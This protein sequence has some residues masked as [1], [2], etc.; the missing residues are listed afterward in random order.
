MDPQRHLVCKSAMNGEPRML[1]RVQEDARIMPYPEAP[2]I[3]ASSD[4]A[5]PEI[6]PPE[7]DDDALV[8]GRDLMA[9]LDEVAAVTGQADRELDQKIK[10]LED[11]IAPMKRVGSLERS[12]QDLRTEVEALRTTKNVIGI[13]RDK[14]EA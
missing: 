7:N 6:I 8:T 10:A 9:I 2:P 13:Q 1:Y 5:P 4:L 14:N 12:M 3:P 11:R